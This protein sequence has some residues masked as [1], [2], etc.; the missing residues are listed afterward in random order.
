V[1]KGREDGVSSS[2]WGH[3][4]ELRLEMGEAP[5]LQETLEG[6]KRFNAWELEEQKRDLPRLSIE[7][8]LTQFLE[9]CD[10]VRA[11]A[12]NA[13]QLFLE[14]DEAHWIALRKKRQ[15]AAKVMGHASTTRRTA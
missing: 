6:Y 13:S 9:L 15:R 2:D 12:P 4:K 11:L 14:Q 1:D 5:T 7:E 8:S 10:L 3:T